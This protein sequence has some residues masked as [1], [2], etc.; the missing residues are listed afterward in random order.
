MYYNNRV[1][2]DKILH[3]TTVDPLLWWYGSRSTRRDE[4]TRRSK[5]STQDEVSIEIRDAERENDVNVARRDSS[6]ASPDR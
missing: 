5:A 6:R 4:D 3:A 1:M 2:E